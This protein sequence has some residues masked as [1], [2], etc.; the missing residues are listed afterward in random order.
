MAKTRKK[1]NLS[2]KSIIGLLRTHSAII[3]ELRKRKVVRTRNNPVQ[4]YAEWL[5]SKKLNLILEPNS[6]TGF[7]ATDRKGTRYEIKGR[8][9]TPSNKSTQLSAIRNLDKKHFDC[10]IGVIF[11][12]DYNIL[13]AAQI[14]HKVISEYSTYK[15][16]TNANIFH[17]RK[18][19]LEDKRVKDI[20]KKLT[21]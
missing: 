11:D 20:T 4:G 21:S 8:R 2:R 10:L 17:L 16:H 7:D 13:Y 18:S 14:P 5:V 12:K 15:A 1:N 9:I 6:N 19:V 3:E